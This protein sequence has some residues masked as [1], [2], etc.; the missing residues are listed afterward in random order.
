MTETYFNHTD[1]EYKVTESMRQFHK[2]AEKEDIAV[3]NVA[4]SMFRVDPENNHR[5]YIGRREDETMLY[6]DPKLRKLLEVTGWEHVENWSD[7][8]F[9]TIYKHDESKAIFTYC[10]GDLTMKVFDNQQDY[11]NWLDECSKFYNHR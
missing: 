7:E 5:K 10:E 1:S 11:N 2:I 4:L 9:R 3:E 6:L 8:P